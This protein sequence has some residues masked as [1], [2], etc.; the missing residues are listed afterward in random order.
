MSK[1]LKLFYVY[2]FVI[3][4]VVIAWKSL[5]TSL[6]GV[7][8]NFV[9]MLVL[10]ALMLMLICTDREIKTRTLDLF[11]ASGVF[12]VL[13]FVLFMALEICNVSLTYGAIKGFSVYQ[14]VLSVLGILYFAYV[15]FRFICDAK[16][17]RFAFIE[18][19]LG[20]RKRE[21]KEKKPKELSNGSLME[22]PSAH[23]ELE[24]VSNFDVQQVENSAGEEAVESAETLDGQISIEEPVLQQTDDENSER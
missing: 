9:V 6:L 3:C 12:A 21:K 7:G 1:S 23:K 19:M 15:V 11:V 17:K 24:E 8:F 16:G 4:G 5:A 14:S 2:A 10:L 13:E 22:K 18:T 20:N